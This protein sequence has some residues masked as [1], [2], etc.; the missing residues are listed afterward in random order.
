MAG[1]K[2]FTCVKYVFIIFNLLFWV[3]AVFFM[4]FTFEFVQ[5][6]AKISDVFLSQMSEV[7]MLP[8]FRCRTKT[9]LNLGCLLPLARKINNI[10]GQMPSFL[11]VIFLLSF[12]LWLRFFLSFEKKKIFIFALVYV[13]Q[14]ELLS[15]VLFLN[16]SHSKILYLLFIPYRIFKKIL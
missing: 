9:V 12:F 8:F 3:S 7:F 16:E 11:S 10:W 2:C 1:G 14:C 5:I 15:L 13:W 4:K 6:P